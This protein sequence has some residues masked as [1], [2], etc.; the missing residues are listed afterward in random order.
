MNG[1]YFCEINTLPGFTSHS[2]YPRLWEKTGLKP[3]AVL[4]RLVGIALRAAADRRRLTTA[5][6]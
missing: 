2:L 6:K 1:V 5:R 4:K 3:A